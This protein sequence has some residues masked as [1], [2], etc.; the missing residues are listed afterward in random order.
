MHIEPKLE[1]E[2]GIN[3]YHTDGATSGQMNSFYSFFLMSHSN[4]RNP[5]EFSVVCYGRNIRRWLHQENKTHHD[6]VHARKLTSART[7]SSIFL[8]IQLL[9]YQFR[10]MFKLP[11]NVL[12]TCIKLICEF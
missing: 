9:S 10:K 5:P 4:I 2:V 3:I 1:D 11:G 6:M 7:W 12:T 8:L